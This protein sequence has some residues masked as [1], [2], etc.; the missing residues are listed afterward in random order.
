MN[1]G[2]MDKEF[3]MKK[4]FVSVLLIS[5]LAATAFAGAG[6]D[7]A[8]S[9]GVKTVNVALESGSRPL[10]YIDENDQKTGYEYD[11][12]LAVDELISEYNFIIDY[13]E[14][15]ATQIGLETGKYV[16]IGG[17][18]YRTREREAKY[19]I[20]EAVNGASLIN[21]YVH[22][23]N[24]SIHGLADLVGK[25]LVPSTPNGGIFNLLTQ[26]NE[27]HPNAQITIT[28]GEGI[29]L[30]DRFRSVDTGQYDAI[31]LPNN[32]GFNEIKDELNLKLK[33]VEPPV[34]V[35]PTYFVLAKDQTDLAAKVTT[36]LLTL[37]NN[38][39]LSELNIKWYGSDP[40]QFLPN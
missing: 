3:C 31:V 39:R 11:V 1:S 36:A 5:A 12:L 7:R 40:L 16:L 28:T 19:L 34:Q 33:A 18:L 24:N 6:S 15:D 35:N 8:A 32:L 20:P 22:E 4:L 21:I 2:F 25:R 26:Y 30:A 14:G 13:V 17:G 10:S 27:A 29:S 37:R 23:N 38:G 9:S